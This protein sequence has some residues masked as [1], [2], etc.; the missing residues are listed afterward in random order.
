MQDEI[1]F[2]PRGTF[3]FELS[4]PQMMEPSS[5]IEFDKEGTIAE[6]RSIVWK[7]W[8]GSLATCDQTLSR[9]RKTFGTRSVNW[10]DAPIIER[11]GPTVKLVHSALQVN[12]EITFEVVENSEIEA[13][14]RVHQTPADDS[15]STASASGR[16]S[17][18]KFI[19]LFENE[20]VINIF[21][22]V[23][24]LH[25]ASLSNQDMKIGRAHV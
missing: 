16:M 20:F 19:Q 1:T 22:Q 17:S 2:K 18:Y 5:W 23:C 4:D 11:I 21:D 14:V 7:K 3:V 6:L 8:P 12:D 10:I 25:P 9:I 15:H 13:I 24:C